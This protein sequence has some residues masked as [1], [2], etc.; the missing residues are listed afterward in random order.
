MYWM[1]PSLKAVLRNRS[2]SCIRVA[3]EEKEL[4]AVDKDCGPRKHATDNT[5]LFHGIELL[6]GVKGSV[7]LVLLPT[8]AVRVGLCLGHVRVRIEHQDHSFQGEELVE[9]PNNTVDE[10]GGQW[11]DTMRD[12]DDGASRAN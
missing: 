4:Q 9:V 5:H 6:S 1:R 12:R 8:L 2:C 7:W 11:T 3:R 10:T